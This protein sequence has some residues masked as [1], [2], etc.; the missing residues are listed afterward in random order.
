MTNNQRLHEIRDT[1]KL[2]YMD[3]AKICD[4]SWF[5]VKS[6]ILH[7]DSEAWRHMPDGRIKLLEDYIAD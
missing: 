7:P 4:R 5:T 6:W 2:T 3:I 1:H